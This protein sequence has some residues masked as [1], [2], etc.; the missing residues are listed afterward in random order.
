M[1]PQALSQKTLD[2]IGNALGSRALS[3]ALCHTH[4]CGYLQTDHAGIALG[5]F[6]CKCASANLW[7]DGVADFSLCSWHFP[8][9]TSSPLTPLLSRQRACCHNAGGK[10]QHSTYGSW[11]GTWGLSGLFS[12]VTPVGA[13]GATHPYVSNHDDFTWH[14]ALWH[15]HLVTGHGSPVPRDS[16]NPAPQHRDVIPPACIHHGVD[17]AH[18]PLYSRC[19]SLLF[20]L[21]TKVFSHRLVPL[22]AGYPTH[23]AHKSCNRLRSLR[24]VGRTTPQRHKSN[25]RQNHAVDFAPPE[26]WPDA[27]VGRGDPQ[28]SKRRHLG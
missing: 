10:G 3:R 19:V 4:F 11:S 23:K 16:R 1:G 14:P 27:E 2:Q 7:I 6:Q 28:D 22:H 24:R 12:R 20:T 25:S 15:G 5:M 21:V 8:G 17:A 26:S 13:T 18:H 9:V